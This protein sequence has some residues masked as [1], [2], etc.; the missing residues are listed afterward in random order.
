MLYSLSVYRND[1]RK[2]YSFAWPLGA[3]KAQIVFEA[4]I[5]AH[6]KRICQSDGKTVRV[7]VCAD[8]MYIRRFLCTVDAF[9]IGFIAACSIFPLVLPVPLFNFYALSMLMHC[10]R[11]RVF[12]RNFFRFIRISCSKP[13]NDKLIA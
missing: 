2:K 5:G 11:L 1:S 12:G 10:T 7:V 9:A 4:N 8:N 3:A 6:K 13:A